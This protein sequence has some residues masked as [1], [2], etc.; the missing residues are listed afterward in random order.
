MSSKKAKKK[1]KKAAKKE[2]KKKAIKTPP[3]SKA[4]KRS[5]LI[6]GAILVFTFIAFS[7]SLDNG[8]VYWDDDKNFL[9]NEL[10]TSIHDDNFW[11]N[12][13]KI[14]KSDV[15]GGYNPLTIFTFAVEKK[16]FGFEQ[17]MYWH[18]NNIILHLVGTFFVF[19]IARRLGLGYFGAGAIAL[20]FGIHPMRVESVAW[21]TER[22]DVLFGA[23]YLCAMFYYI[24]GKQEGFKKKYI[25]II[26]IS[27]VLS[28]LSKIQA[29][30]LPPTL[31]LIDYYMSK[32]S[33]ITFKSIINKWPLFIGSL[34]IGLV[35]IMFLRENGSI[36]QQ[37]FQGVSRVFIGSYQLLTYYIKSIFPFRLSPLYPYPSSLDWTFYTSILSFIG[38][39]FALWYTY[40][41]KLKVWFFGIGIFIV[42]VFLLLQIVGAGQGFLA[43]RFTYIAY[44]GLFF[45]IA[46]YADKLYVKKGSLSKILLALSAIIALA[47]ATM[48]FQQNKVW[49][50]SEALWSHV[51]KHY[52]KTTLPFGNRANYRRDYSQDLLKS[53]NRYKAQNNMAEYQR[54]KIESD[55]YVTLALKDYGEVIKLAPN[56]PNAYNSRARLYFNF[57]EPDS[58]RKA[59]HNYNKAI[60]LNPN[61]V[62]YQ[63]NRGATFA[64]L[65]DFNNAI[66]SLNH[67]QTIDPQF[68]NIYLNRSVI[69]SMQGQHPLAL[70]D[71]DQ[72]LKFR[73]NRPDMWYEK[74]N[75]HNLLNQQNQGL[76]ALNKALSM[77]QKGIYYFERAKSYHG[78]RQYDNARNDL[79]S[80]KRLGY[81]GPQ[82]VINRIMSAQ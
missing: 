76:T 10:I 29:V 18:L 61:D 22:K 42:N 52:N 45:I 77:Q 12:A 63:V 81:N 44:F 60:E 66:K 49:K 64:K 47:F 6:I 50:D 23:F 59:L 17:P 57:S 71:I 24:K 27:F 55:K 16:L 78:L 43:D 35:N 15:I 8:F 19:F 5:L 75:I 82:D 68:V 34:V 72:Y 40:I 53:A 80:A 54:L 1:N 37:Q 21:V 70:Q 4:D 74:A 25:A 67:A 48:T 73:P 26:G 46:Y 36:E 28:L 2:L 79:Q 32:D 56:K 14:F 65:G 62:E 51:L 11:E 7:P 39:L 30:L 69:Y 3:K 20:L 38:T 33:K 13:G 58:L 9:E 41:K 31:I